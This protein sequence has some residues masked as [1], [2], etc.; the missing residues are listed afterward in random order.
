[1][2]GHEALPPRGATEIAA[3]DTLHMLVRREVAGRIQDLLARWRGIPPAAQA[4]AQVFTRPWTQQDGD[5]GDPDLVGG[6]PVTGLLRARIGFPAALVALEDGS[7]AVTGPTLVAG[8]A[9]Q[10]LGYAQA[11]ASAA[12]DAADRGWWGEVAV[13]LGAA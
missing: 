11:R 10:L 12:R 2:R 9:G 3:G 13:A 8:S 4:A 5:P 1:V 6:I 7:F